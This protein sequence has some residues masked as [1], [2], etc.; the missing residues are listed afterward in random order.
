[1]E[2]L[3]ERMPRNVEAY[4]VS[5]NDDSST[6]LTTCRELLLRDAV[7]AAT[8]PKHQNGV[9]VQ[10]VHERCVML[11]DYVSSQNGHGSR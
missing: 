5:P 10:M 6:Q 4:V 11:A 2:D 7:T 9:E 1:M 8:G 3:P